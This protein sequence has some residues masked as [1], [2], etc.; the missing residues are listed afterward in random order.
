MKRALG[1]LGLCARAGKI[2]SGEHACQ[3]AIKHGHAQL[4]LLDGAASP[5]TR[6]AY[7][8][9]CAHH[10]I[11]IRLTDAD[12]LGTAIGKPDRRVAVVTDEKLAKKLADLLPDPLA[13]EG[14][15]GAAPIHNH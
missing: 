4:I 15:H 11:P 3:L 2:P 7:F 14:E 10:H 9:A 6:K 5:L 8:D 1:L 12:A 13:A